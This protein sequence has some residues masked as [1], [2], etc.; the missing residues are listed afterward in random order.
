MVRFAVRVADLKR[1]WLGALAVATSA[2]EA[3]ARIHGL[4][5]RERRDHIGHIRAERAWLETV[6]WP[7]V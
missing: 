2:V 6:D 4:P 3:A 7:A 5:A 1:R